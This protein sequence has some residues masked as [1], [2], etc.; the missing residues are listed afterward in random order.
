MM[1]EYGH[2]DMI[3]ALGLK[4]LLDE[5]PILYMYLL[6]LFSLKKEKKKIRAD[7]P[8]YYFAVISIFASPPH[9]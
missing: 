3:L 4:K 7:R 6:F 1:T 2:I 9:H 5:K 8:P